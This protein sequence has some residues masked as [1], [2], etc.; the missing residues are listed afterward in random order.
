M[1]AVLAAGV[2]SCGGD[3]TNGGAP[4]PFLFAADDP[5]AYAR[6][7]RAGSPWTARL[8]LSGA[9]RQIFNLDDP[10]D[11]A[12]GDWDP[13]FAGALRGLHAQLDTALVNFGLEPCDSLDCVSQM[14]ALIRGDVITLNLEEAPGFPN[15]RFPNDPAADLVLAHLLLDLTGPGLCGLN[16]CTSGTLAGIPLNPDEN[17]LVFG[18]F[19][20]Y[21]AVPHAP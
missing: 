10:A 4:D 13:S 19:I 8:L 14:R 16:P 12:N 17:D 9:E 20:P 11:V 3:G 15:G 1:C 18:G 21:L 2:M 7:D 6:V 5:S